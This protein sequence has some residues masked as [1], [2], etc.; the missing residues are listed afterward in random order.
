LIGKV[1]KNYIIAS[2]ASVL[3]SLMNSW[4]PIMKALHLVGQTSNNVIYENLYADIAVRVSEWKKLVES[5]TLTDE[6]AK[7][8][9]PDFIQLLSVWERTATVGTVCKKLNESYTREVNYSLAN[10]TKWIEPIAILVAWV[11]VLWFAF[12]IFGAILQLTQTVG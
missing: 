10:L 9:P 6:Q 1:Y 5:I 2:T 7:Y 3:G 4:V 11:F 12:A 8:F